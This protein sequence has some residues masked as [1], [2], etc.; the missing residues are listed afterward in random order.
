MSLPTSESVNPESMPFLVHFQEV[1]DPITTDG[2]EV[3]PAVVATGTVQTKSAFTE[4]QSQNRIYGLGTATKQV[5]IYRTVVGDQ[6]YMD[7]GY[8]PDVDAN[9]VT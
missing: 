9:P 3:D 8:D 2:K 7:E 6:A 4:D 1:L 5:Y